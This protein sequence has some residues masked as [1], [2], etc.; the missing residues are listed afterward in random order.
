MLAAII[1]IMKL[2]ILLLLLQLITARKMM[3][4]W[5]KVSIP[6]GNDTSTSQLMR[7]F[8]KKWKETAIV[9]DYAE[10][11]NKLQFSVGNSLLG[12]YLKKLSF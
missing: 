1:I 7:E 6:E 5:E 2:I 3:A 10:S 4:T 9:P 12:D 11:V 8:F